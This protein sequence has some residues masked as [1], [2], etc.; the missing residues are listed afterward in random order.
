[1][2][3][4][5]AGL[6]GLTLSFYGQPRDREPLEVL[7]LSELVTV[8]VKDGDLVLQMEGQGQEV[9]MKVRDTPMGGTLGMKVPT[10]LELLPGHLFQLMEALREERDRRATPGAPTPSVT[11]NPSVTTSTL[12]LPLVPSC[13]FEVTRLEAERLLEQS[14]GRGNMVLRPG[15]HGQGVSVTTRQERNG[16]VLLNHYRV[17]HV[18]QGYVIDVDTQHRCSSLAEVVQYFVEKSKGILQPL[19]RE[20]S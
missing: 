13:F 1:Y 10:D 8:R 14:V 3:R 12:K 4:V 9:M 2:R 16:T 5:W 6:R 17:A 11:P 15:G 7:D 19:Q 20:Y 18:D